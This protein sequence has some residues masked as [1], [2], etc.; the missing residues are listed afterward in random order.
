[1]HPKASHHSINFQEY[2][3]V[4]NNTHSVSQGHIINKTGSR[5]KMG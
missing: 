2:S 5:T 4:F 1:M 3:Y